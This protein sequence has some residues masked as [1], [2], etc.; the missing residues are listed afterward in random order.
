[1]SQRPV[2]VFGAR[3]LLGRA[4]GRALTQ[5]GRPWRTA[6]VAWSTPDA[7]EHAVEAIESAG[8]QW[9]DDWGVAWCA[10]A[11]VT[12]ATPVQVDAEVAA[13]TAIVDTLLARDVAPPRFFLASS[14]G[15]VFAGA[16]DPP[17]TELTTPSPLA[18]YGHG[19]LRL[20]EQARRLAGA[21][22]QV[23][24]G[25]ISN[26]YGPGQ[27]LA[28]DQGLVSRLIRSYLLRQ[29]IGIYVSLD[30][31]RDYIYVDD[32]AQMVLDAL[33]LLA[34][35]QPTEP[36]LKIFAAQ[37]ATTIAGLLGYSRAVLGRN[38]LVT[39]GGSDLAKQQ[40]RDLRFR[41]V[42]W[43]ELDRRTFTTLPDGIHATSQDLR[44]SL[45][46]GLL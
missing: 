4:V 5:D 24:V 36:V 14:A 44:R 43:T 26:L 1:M 31:I 7:A 45:V 25:R 32:C 29:P 38:V 8:A 6:E 20:E 46:A 16:A 15:G 13:M 39:L 21:G 37:Q 12:A 41:S 23:L 33:D 3:G 2:L 35:R 30:T 40:A 19:K 28:K 17:F 22:T 11:S 9:G 27:N 34:V 42:V 10:G 18:A